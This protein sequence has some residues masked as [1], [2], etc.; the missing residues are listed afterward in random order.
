MSAERIL[1]VSHGHPDLSPG[2]GE[3][4]AYSQW[5]ELRRQGIE[6]VFLAYSGDNQGHPG[7]PFSARSADG[8]EMLFHAPPI[9]PFKQSQTQRRVVYEDFREFLLTFRPT[10]VHFHHY[11]HLGLELIREARHYSAEIPIILTLHEYLGMCNAFGQMLK[12]NGMLCQ[13]A[14][15]MDCSNCF[16]ERSPQ[17][18][19]L[20]ELFVKS[21]FSLVDRF[22]C[23][24]VFLRDRYVAWGLPLERMVVL[25]N[26][27]PL[28]HNLGSDQPGETGKTR[29]SANEPT[30]NGARTRFVVIGQLSESKGTRVVL[31]AAMMLPKRLKDRIRIEVHGSTQIKDATLVA[32]L[33]SAHDRLNPLLRYCGPYLHANVDTILERADWV[34]V[35]SLWWENSP[36]VIQEAFRAGRPVICSNIGGMAEKV[37]DGINGLHFMAGNAADLAR[38]IENAATSPGLWERLS[39]AIPTP[40]NI[41]DTVTSQ[42]LLYR[43]GRSAVDRPATDLRIV[44]GGVKT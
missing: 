10:A 16:P 17:D 1:I 20:R 8:R 14:H 44:A 36:L 19:F 9:D 26:G 6:A 28:P 39:Q 31:D 13:R 33:R 23:P 38:C 22:V 40:V 41:R 5:Q 24:S 7:T 34:I 2:G 29:A 3:I 43:S 11:A 12:T 30:T 18:F 27:Q 32:S 37:E 35:P 15:P 42:L 4:A 21:F 25:E